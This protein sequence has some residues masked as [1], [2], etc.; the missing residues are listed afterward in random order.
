MYIYIYIYIYGHVMH[1]IMLYNIYV[2]NYKNTI[3]YRRHEINNIWHN[4]YIY[5]YTNTYIYVFVYIPL[6]LFII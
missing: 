6:S 3:L 2:N 4:N 5:I 1:V